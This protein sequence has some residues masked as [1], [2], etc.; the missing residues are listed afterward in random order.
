MSGF[1]IK[2]L[3]PTLIVDHLGLSLV[4]VFC[5]LSC[6]WPRNQARDQQ[7]NYC[8]INNNCHGCQLISFTFY[9]QKTPATLK[10]QRFLLCLL[11]RGKGKVWG[12][13]RF[14]GYSIGP[15]DISLDTRDTS[16][17]HPQEFIWNFSGELGR[18]PFLDTEV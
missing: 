16:Q 12:Y 3:L 8:G 13:S 2:A 17:K 5:M 10:I 6:D 1:Q 15:L 7:N 4:K 14:M 11:E 9:T 18:Y